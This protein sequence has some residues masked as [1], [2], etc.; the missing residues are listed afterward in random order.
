MLYNIFIIIVDVI[1]LLGVIGIVRS[2]HKY[3]VLMD[4][5][6]KYP[7]FGGVEVKVVRRHSLEKGEH[8]K[9]TF[10]RVDRVI[11]IALNNPLEDVIDS[12]LHERRHSEQ[13]FGDNI[14][15][16]EMY[17]QSVGALNYLRGQ[18]F[19]D[20]TTYFMSDHEI[21]AREEASRLTKEYL[22]SR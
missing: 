19:N 18:G 20:Y 15:L 7:T 14:R 17:A 2:I 9:G 8:V 12:Y 4:V 5:I 1:L 13:A 10:S 11:E 21:D 3:T 16:N 6:N 22:A